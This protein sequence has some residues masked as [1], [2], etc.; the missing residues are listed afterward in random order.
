LVSQSKSPSYFT[1]QEG[2]LPCLEHPVRCAYPKPDQSNK[3]CP[4]QIFKT[5][6]SNKNFINNNELN[7]QVELPT[8]DRGLTCI[9]TVWGGN[10]FSLKRE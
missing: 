7:K 5:P 9:V 3:H 10:V 8:S 6:N 1:V 2:S 4:T